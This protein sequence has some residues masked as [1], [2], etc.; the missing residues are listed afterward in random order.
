MIVCYNENINIAVF[1]LNFKRRKSR[2]TPE[3]V[4]ALPNITRR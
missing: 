3:F 1:N 4:D 2:V